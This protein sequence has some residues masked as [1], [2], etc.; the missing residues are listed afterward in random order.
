[1]TKIRGLKFHK[2]NAK[3]NEYHEKAHID[4][5]LVYTSVFTEGL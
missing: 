5:S 4:A 2:V 3:V 1:M